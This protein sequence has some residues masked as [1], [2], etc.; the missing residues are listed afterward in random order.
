M[1]MLVQAKVPV[2]APADRV[3]DYVTDWPRF[4]EWVPLTRVEVVPDDSGDGRARHVG[5]RFR[6]WTG[7]GP[8]GFWDPITVTAWDQQVDGSVRVEVLHTGRL[9]RG[10]A[11]L[12]VQAE[13]P[14]ACTVSLREHLEVPGGPVGAL[15]WRLL[16]P[17]LGPA[18]D[19]AAAA[20]LRRMARRVEAGHV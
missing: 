15:L 3:R 9:V 18:L 16:G 19:R 8:V 11:E 20:V 12:G 13:G 17:L 7:L 6:A 2:A 4:G 10:D 1:R 5:G 14:G